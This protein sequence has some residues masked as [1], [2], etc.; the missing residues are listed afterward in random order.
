MLQ[1]KWL[2]V[3]YWEPVLLLWVWGV[4]FK[5][6]LELVDE[7]LCLFLITC[8]LGLGYLRL[9][10]LLYYRLQELLWLEL[11]HW[12]YPKQSLADLCRWVVGTVRENI[13]IRDAISEEIEVGPIDKVTDMNN[14]SKVEMSVQLED[15]VHYYCILFQGRSICIW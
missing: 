12:L 4:L 2:I 5:L 3:L 14:G 15:L 10:A 13:S 1:H 7:H 6:K 9:V 8:W 11:N